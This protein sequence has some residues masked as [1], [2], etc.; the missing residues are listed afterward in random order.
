VDSLRLI[1][2]NLENSVSVLKLELEERLSDIDVLKQ[3][4]IRRMEYE[5]EMKALVVERKL[6]V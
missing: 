2:T 4:I 1:I 3:D 5:S 6:W